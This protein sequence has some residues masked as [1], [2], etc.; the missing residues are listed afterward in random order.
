MARCRIC[1]DEN[2]KRHSFKLSA[3]RIK[4]FSGSSPP[5]IFIG[6]YNYP[7]VYVGILSPNQLGDT[8]LLSSQEIWHEKM[9]LMK[10][11]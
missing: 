8:S 5:E 4:N 11:D 10:L 1:G 7:N 6:R 2:C 3:K 9:M